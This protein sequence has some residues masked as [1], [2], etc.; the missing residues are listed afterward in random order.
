MDE[1]IY[2]RHRE[3]KC[4]ICGGEAKSHK[5]ECPEGAKEDMKNFVF[6]HA[7]YFDPSNKKKIGAM[8]DM[9]TKR[10]S[11]LSHQERQGVL[12]KMLSEIEEKMK[13]PVGAKQIEKKEVDL[14]N[15]MLDKLY[16][17]GEWR[18]N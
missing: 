6:E 17:G 5:K 3:S 10:W 7:Q 2:K 15:L 8:I 1:F 14:I 18:E 4:P 9:E 16:P 13:T 12:K 11:C